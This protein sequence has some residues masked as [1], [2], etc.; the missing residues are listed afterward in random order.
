MEG[1]S[2]DQLYQMGLREERLGSVNAA[3]FKESSAKSHS[4]CGLRFG[5]ATVLGPVA[6]PLL[7]SL[8]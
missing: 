4:T 2:H 6:A 5:N 7:S 3:L 1:V 8:G